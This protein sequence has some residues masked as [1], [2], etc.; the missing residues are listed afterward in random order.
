MTDIAAE[1]KEIENAPKIQIIYGAVRR[2]HFCGA[3]AKELRKVETV[4]Q[5]E[6]F[7]CERHP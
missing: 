2:C 6:R 3:I 5:V 1:K 4:D 7:K